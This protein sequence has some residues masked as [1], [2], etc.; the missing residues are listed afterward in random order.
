MTGRLM[1]YRWW[2]V[3]ML[4]SDDNKWR[5]WREVMMV[6]MM[7]TGDDYGMM[8]G[9]DDDRP[10][11]MMM[12]MMMMMTGD[13]NNRWWWCSMT[14]S[15]RRSRSL[16]WSRRTLHR[17]SSGPS[18]CIM[19]AGRH[20]THRLRRNKTQP[21]IGPISICTKAVITIAIRLRHDYDTTIPRRIR[22][23]RKWSKLRFDCDTTTTRL[24]RKIDMLIFCSRRMETGTRDT[25]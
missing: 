17:F 21:H 16:P 1:T 13:D 19:Y 11:M 12:M 24:R 7:I 2:Q 3:M 15:T 4:T 23:R 9:N 18:I 14:N 10:V 22:L 8:P 6:M 25:S 20:S 5:W